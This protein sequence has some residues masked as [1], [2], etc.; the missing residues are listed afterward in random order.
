MFGILFL[1]LSGLA[2]SLVRLKI[3]GS[4]CPVLDASRCPLLP[5]PTSSRPP[6]HVPSVPSFLCVSLVTAV[7][8]CVVQLSDFVT[9]SGCVC[10]CGH[11]VS[12][13]VSV[14]LCLSFCESFIRLCVGSVCLSV[15]ILAGLL[16]CVLIL[17]G[18]LSVSVFFCLSVYILQVC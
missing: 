11:S 13:S 1:S 7:K 10:V 6:T 9:L 3:Y 8:I 17:S 12:V 5:P 4:V 16:V 14:C 18:C 2:L 15:Y